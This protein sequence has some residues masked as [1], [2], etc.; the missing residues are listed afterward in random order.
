MSLV[1]LR[2]SKNLKYFIETSLQPHIVLYDCHEAVSNYGTIDLDADSI[3]FS[4]H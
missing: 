4:G 1:I 3:L 2:D